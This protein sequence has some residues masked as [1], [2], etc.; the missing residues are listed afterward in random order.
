MQKRN[1]KLLGF[2]RGFMT[3]QAERQRFEIIR[4]ENLHLQ[5]CYTVVV[6]VEPLKAVPLSS[7]LLGRKYWSG[8]P[9]SFR[10]NTTE[11]RFIMEHPA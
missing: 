6:T 10:V 8:H 11:A 9:F 7:I 5:R 1:R 3:T 2:R 4:Q